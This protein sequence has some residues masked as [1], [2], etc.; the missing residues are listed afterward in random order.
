MYKVPSFFGL[1]DVGERRHRCA[2]YSSD[3]NLVKILIGGAAFEPR[4]GGEVIGPDGLVVAIGERGR[5]G[6]ISVAFLAVALPAFQFLEKFLPMLDALDRELW[7][8][9][10]GDRSPRLVTLPARR[11]SLDEGDQVRTVLVRQGDPRRHVAVVEA[12]LNS[13]EQILVSR[14]SSGRGRSAL[15]RCR[16]EIARQNIQIRGVFAVAIAAKTVVSPAV[17]EIELF[18][19]LGMPGPLADMRFHLL[20]RC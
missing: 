8:R 9:R 13:V 16:H 14:Q 10:H 3:E 18:A 20:G 11:K 2:I 4:A 12:A 15:E 19:D 6:T 1:D 5:R 17:P 7:L